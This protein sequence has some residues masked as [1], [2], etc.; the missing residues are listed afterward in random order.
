ML[1][2]GVA[3]IPGGGLERKTS[4][5]LSSEKSSQSVGQIG[6]STSHLPAKGGGGGAGVVTDPPPEISTTKISATLGA[7][8]T[9]TQIERSGKAKEEKP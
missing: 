1:G 5:P 6:S 8:P 7:E 3:P 4:Q 2:G 9:D